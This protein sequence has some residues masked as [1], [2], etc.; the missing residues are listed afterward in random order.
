MALTT[1]SPT[2]SDTAQNA[3]PPPVA[4]GPQLSAE[5]Q[6]AVAKVTEISSL[7]EV[8]T[9]II[10]VVEDPKS[11][12]QDMHEIVK[13]DPALAAKVL[14]VV[15]SAFYGLPTQIANLDRAIV[16][17]GLS[18]VKN[19][20]M[21][22]SLARLFKPGKLSEKFDARDLWRHCIAVGVCARTLAETAGGHAEEAFVGGLVHDMGLLVEYQLFPD[23]LKAI[24][25]RVEADRTLDFCT[26]EREL[27]GADHQAFGNFMAT[28]WKFPPGLRACISFHHNT[29]N[30]KA[31]HKRIVSLVRIA[32]T[33]CCQ[34][35][36]GF[37]L[38]AI[39][40]EV[41]T[42]ALTEVGLSEDQVGGVLE[43]LPEKLAEAEAIFHD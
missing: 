6:K 27:I 38:T 10:A 28:K 29:E 16:M 25:E 14:K 7:P 4:S 15:N 21:A 2:T 3:A 12:A 23:K 8:T 17:L 22:A 41:T 19:L 34:N 30:L 31:D 20:A 33:I 24:V 5:L 39:A 42:D 18:A 40:Q 32:D 37:Y 1:A 35:E 9:K 11:T 43:V 36:L 13:N 26:V